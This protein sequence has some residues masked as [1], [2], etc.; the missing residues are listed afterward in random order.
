MEFKCPEC[1]NDQVFE[2]KNRAKG[3]I[4]TLFRTDGEEAC[5]EGMYNSL[6]EKPMKYMYCN[7]CGARQKFTLEQLL[8]KGK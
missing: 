1:G 8:N 7:Q 4:T 5:N 2:Q 3:I 6:T